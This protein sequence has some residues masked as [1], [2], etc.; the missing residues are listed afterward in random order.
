M[1]TIANRLS[2]AK[3]QQMNSFDKSVNQI[4]DLFCDE[5]RAE[6]KKLIVEREED[7]KEGKG[8]EI[9]QYFIDYQMVSFKQK[10]MQH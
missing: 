1:S 2:S 3:E 5:M 7:L 10:C 8:K 9:I 4:L 6:L